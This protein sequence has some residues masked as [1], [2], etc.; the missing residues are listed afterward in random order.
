VSAAL[1]V[2]HVTKYGEADPA[3]GVV[4]RLPPH[5]HSR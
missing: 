4:P 5:R 2:V 1:F 3:R